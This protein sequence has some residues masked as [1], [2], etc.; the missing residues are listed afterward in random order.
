M[1]PPAGAPMDGARPPPPMDGDGGPRFGPS[2]GK[3]DI[4]YTYSAAEDCSGAVTQNQSVTFQVSRTNDE[5]SHRAQRALS[6][7]GSAIRSDP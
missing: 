2:S 7:A 1:P 5:D 6:R 4:A 3:V